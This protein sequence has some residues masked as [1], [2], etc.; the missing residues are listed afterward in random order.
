MDLEGFTMI[1]YKP[2]QQDPYAQTL[3]SV[4]RRESILALVGLCAGVLACVPG[5]L[6]EIVPDSGALGD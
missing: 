2:G 1:G 3:G 6:G 4:V 5:G